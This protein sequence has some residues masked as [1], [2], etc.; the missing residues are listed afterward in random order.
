M[1]SVADLLGKFCGLFGIH[2]NHGCLHSVVPIMH[3]AIH[4][5]LSVRAKALCHWFTRIEVF[6][7]IV[8]LSYVRT[9]KLFR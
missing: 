3:A 5:H 9:H 2:S 8:A 4:S 6:G 7:Q 1:Y